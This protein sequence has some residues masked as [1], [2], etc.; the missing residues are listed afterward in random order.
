[1][2]VVQTL[3]KDQTATVVADACLHCGEPLVPR[4]Q[5][6]CCSGCALVH[7]LIERRGWQEYY[8][9]RALNQGLPNQNKDNPAPSFGYLNT[10]S[11]YEKH[12]RRRENGYQGTWYL[13]GLHCAACVW[14]IEKLVQN[15]S[16][17][18]NSELYFGTG[19][20]VLW[21]RPDT[22]LE[23]LANVIAAAGYQVGLVPQVSGEE[24]RDL[25]RLGVSGA[26]A[27]NIMLMSLPFYTGLEDGGFA[28]L[29]A[30]T[31]FV[32]SLPLLAYG[33]KPF[34]KRAGLALRT[35]CLNLD[36]PIVIGL[37][38][39]F[40]LSTYSLVQGRIGDL[41]FDSMGMLVF[42]LLTGRYIQNMGVKRAL[43]ETQRLLA[44]MPQMVLCREG[45]TW[46][47]K[48]VEYLK[49]GDRLRFR[50]GDLVP[51][52][53]VLDSAGGV[54]NLHVVSG[55]AEPVTL[56]RG[57]QVLA[58]SVNLAGLVE[59]ILENDAE[60]SRFAHFQEKSQ[61]LSHKK[62]QDPIAEAAARWFLPAAL[63]VA[64]LG[65]V[66]WYPSAPTRA[67]SVAL[68]VLIV[69]CPCALALA[70]PTARAWG[71]SRAAQAGIWIK[72]PEV[73]A[74]MDQVD[75][76]IFDKT[77]VITEGLPKLIETRWYMGRAHW[78]KAAICA[79]EQAGHHP[80]AQMFLAAW[81]T[82]ATP[83][84]TLASVGEVQALPGV[85]VRGT[86]DGC[87]LVV[88]SLAAVP[89][90]C[91]D[92]ADLDAVDRLAAV[93]DAGHS[94]VAV[95]NNGR[96]AGTFT[97]EDAVGGEV[98]EAM[99]CL[100]RLGLQRTMLSGDRQ[101]VVDKLTDLLG[102]EQGL[103]ARQPEEKLAYVA[104]GDARVCLMVGD[105]LNDMGALAAAD[106]GVTHALGTGAALEFADV[107][108][109]R[110]DLTAIDQLFD[111]AARVKRA[112]R[113]GLTLSLGYNLV[114]VSLSLAGLI[115]PL[116]A[117]VLMPLS[118]LSVIAVSA[119]TLR[120]RSR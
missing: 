36:V 119:W 56:T 97:L 51:V 18:I 57:E 87:D 39:A 41:Y 13:E 35:R 27:G 42:F 3:S 67:F 112:T 49:A 101:A 62:H 44:A 30:W 53:G 90:F 45:E 98:A 20:L 60:N 50:A 2:R 82:P 118:S 12:C 55:E 79:L 59:I 43:R 99:A 115:G 96:L 120:Q 52:D 70:E 102:M 116:I 38:S 73:F 110:R 100:A 25:L 47:E 85:G 92:V 14:L 32:L 81:Q 72:R 64:L 66:L 9:L 46:I 111:L 78:Y 76:V 107:V 22:D 88:C 40:G 94:A 7:D 26:L 83:A 65:F 114:A 8:R 33:A 23:G 31:A 61:K 48:P 10:Q 109:R 103:G 16:G 113:R 105:G 58:G 68:T 117:A 6:F 4:Q 28:L 75:E 93:L 24:G 11:Y 63:T 5:D 71:L 19:K 54:F 34:F 91:R 80:M 86:I 37:L 108:L 21:F 1:M 17:V 104:E 74:R 106:I 95:L 15:C 69:V 89:Q 29:F 77:G 84:P